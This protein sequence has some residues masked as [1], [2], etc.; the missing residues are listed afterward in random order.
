VCAA[1]CGSAQCPATRSSLIASP[2]FTDD[3]V[4]ND[5]SYQCIWLFNCRRPPASSVVLEFLAFDRRDD[6]PVDCNH[7]FV[8]IREGC[9]RSRRLE[10]DAVWVVDSGGLK[11]AQV[12]SYLPGGANVSSCEGILAPPGECD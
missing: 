5:T 9:L 10:E 3:A 8:E 4:Y 2:D 1:V 12:E 7:N 6:S 11:E